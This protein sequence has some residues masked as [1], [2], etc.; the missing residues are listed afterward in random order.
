MIA[1]SNKR[2]DGTSRV[3]EVNQGDGL[4]VLRIDVSPGNCAAVVTATDDVQ[5][6]LM[7]KPDVRGPEPTPSMWRYAL[8]G[9]VPAED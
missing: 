3:P 8:G 2:R 7:Q 6:V 4:N 1:S 9:H 5:L